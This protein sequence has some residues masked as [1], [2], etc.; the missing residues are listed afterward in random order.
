MRQSTGQGVEDDM[1]AGDALGA[2]FADTTLPEG[3]RV[4]L[5]GLRRARTY[6]KRADR[7]FELLEG[8]VSIAVS[9]LGLGSWGWLGRRTWQTG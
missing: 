6:R 3:S 4:M 8:E 2:A 1:D 7:Q 5:G 9:C